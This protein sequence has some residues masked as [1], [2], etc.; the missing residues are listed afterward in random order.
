MKND[1]KTISL[2]SGEQ[3]TDEKRKFRE[4]R[5]AL[6]TADR[7][8]FNAFDQIGEIIEDEFGPNAIK[9]HRTKNQAL[10]QKVLGPYFLK[11]LL[12]DLQHPD[13]FFSLLTDETTDISV[14]KLLTFS[15]RYYSSRFKQIKETHLDLKEMIRANA[16]LLTKATGKF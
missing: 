8:S 12:K 6:A 10:V 16:E 5:F 2:F 15:V 11:E 9:L 1:S 7:L 3:S 13:C 4:L 14:T